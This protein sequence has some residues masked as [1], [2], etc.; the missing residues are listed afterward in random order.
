MNKRDARIHIIVSEDGVRFL[1]RDLLRELG[2]TDIVLSGKFEAIRIAVTE[3]K[4]DLLILGTS[5][6]D[7]DAL[8]MIAD[9][10]QGRLGKN[11]FLPMM[12]ITLEPTS[13]LVKKVVNSGADDLLLYPLSLGHLEQRLDLLIDN[14]K[15]F[16]VTVDYAGPDRRSAD[17]V[18]EHSTSHLLFDA[19]NALR[20]R[21]KN[22]MT[23]KEMQAAIA[24]TVKAMD[25]HR[26]D[27]YMRRICWFV[28]RIDAGYA[29]AGDGILEPE[30]S[31]FLENL[32]STTK[33]ALTVIDEK[34]QS[35]YHYLCS[36]VL[37]VTAR[38]VKQGSEIE[39][40]D[41]KVLVELSR[42]IK[43]ALE[44]DSGSEIS[45]HIRD[46]VSKT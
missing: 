11:P 30:V 23:D 29:W 4:P 12:A 2:Y 26:A 24:R 16:L 46:A 31:E 22:D 21:V 36:T 10:R 17:S 44:T 7:G 14:R 20:A 45:R 1:L 33:Q 43:V 13:H 6:P 34:E 40:K 3:N 35:V 39:V 5:F 32:L 41:R 37:T 9:V 27:S 18:R 28:D 25:G 8:E 38:L 15:K 19:P 42:A